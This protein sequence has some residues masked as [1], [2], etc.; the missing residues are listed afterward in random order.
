MNT[1]LFDSTLMRGLAAGTLAALLVALLSYAILNVEKMQYAN[2]M[3]TTISV[4][5]EGEVMAVPDIGQFTFSVL[6]E[7]EDAAT[8]QELSGTSIND[9][10]AYLKEAGVEEKDIKTLNYNLYPRYRWVEEVCPIGVPCRGG[11]QVQ[12]GFEVNQSVQVKIRNTD[13]ASG[14]I[15]RVGELGATNISGLDFVIDDTDALKV[16]ARELAIADAK[17]K[18]QTL[19][20]DLGVDLVRIAGYYEESN[21]Y[22][23]EP[24]SMR[25]M[26]MDEMAESGFGGAAL[27]MGED[28]TS[29]RVTIIYE[30]K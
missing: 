24:Y 16:E 1:S 2:P 5:G 4:S 12:D 19:A 17:T 8:A 9:I 23:P 29:A 21:Q 6:A 13:D 3:P 28:A 20:D 15:T 11:E 22:Y 14:I 30:I 10:I 7:A 18:A 27:P 26:A 25:N